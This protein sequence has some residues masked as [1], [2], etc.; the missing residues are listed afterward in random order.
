MIMN[1][2]LISVIVPVYNEK[3]NIEQLYLRIRQVFEARPEEFELIFIDDGS[4]DGSH[5]V[6]QDLTGSDRQVRVLS[7]TRNF[8]HQQA[9]SAGLK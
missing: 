8:G 1:K 5:E 6:L 4:T 9:V 7:F 2:I 3:G